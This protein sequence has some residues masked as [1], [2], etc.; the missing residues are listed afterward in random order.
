M[1]FFFSFS[2]RT[3]NALCLFYICLLLSL[4]LSRTISITCSDVAVVVCF[5]FTLRFVF[6]A[7]TVIRLKC[8]YLQHFALAQLVWCESKSSTHSHNSLSLS[9]FFSR[10]A[11]TIYW[12]KNVR[13]SQYERDEYDYHCFQHR[14]LFFATFRWMAVMM[15][16]KNKKIYTPCYA[17]PNHTMS[18]MMS[19]KKTAYMLKIR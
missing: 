9:L 16:E 4:S 7:F 19:M 10:C 3:V 15:C 11:I 12:M 14:C 1:L 8:S 2:F 5:F 17:I 6:G 13:F 18:C